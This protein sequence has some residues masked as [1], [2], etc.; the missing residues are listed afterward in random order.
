MLCWE[1]RVMMVMVVIG[2]ALA[3]DPCLPRLSVDYAPRKIGLASSDILGQV[4]GLQTI[5]HPGNLVQL[6]RDILSRAKGLRAAEVLVGL[7]TD[8]CGTVHEG[9][10]N[11]NGKLSLNF[12]RVLCTIASNEYEYSRIAVKLFDERYTTQ[13]AQLRLGS[14]RRTAGSLDSMAAACLL[15]R[16]LRCQGEGALRA[17][18]GVHGYPVPA[19]IALFD[20]E[21]VRAHGRA[22]AQARFRDKGKQQ[23]PV[24]VR[25]QSHR[26]EGGPLPEGDWDH[27]D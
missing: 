13:E 8:P 11:F 21:T 17:S 24:R 14:E 25:Q 6:S 23:Q 7:P 12:S 1:L 10:R 5:Q 15:E 26:Q 16:Y 22:L 3:F 19:A 9:V 27:D 4:R 2:L 20:Y 18:Q